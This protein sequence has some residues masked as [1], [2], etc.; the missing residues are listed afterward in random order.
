MNRHFSKDNIQMASRYMKNCSS[1]IIMEMQIKTTM[2]CQFLP[3]VRMT[4]FRQKIT[5]AG[6]DVKK[7]KSYILLVRM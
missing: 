4:I 3:S 7:R 5:D 2:R 6:E 1:L